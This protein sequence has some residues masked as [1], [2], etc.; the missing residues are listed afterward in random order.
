VQSESITGT[1]EQSEWYAIGV[2]RGWCSTIVC[3]THEGLPVD[4]FEE[5]S[6]EEGLDLCVHGVRIYE[7]TEQ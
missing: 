3:V 6:F 7:Q 4:A 2:D 5:E 1:L